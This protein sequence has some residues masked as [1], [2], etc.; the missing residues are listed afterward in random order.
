MFCVTDL[1]F[2]RLFGQSKMLVAAANPETLIS[3]GEYLGLVGFNP[4][5]NT[6]KHQLLLLLKK[7]P[8]TKQPR[9]SPSAAILYVSQWKLATLHEHLA[10][11]K[12]SAVIVC[13]RGW[14]KTEAAA[15]TISIWVEAVRYQPLVASGT[16]LW[17]GCLFVFYGD[18]IC[19]DLLSIPNLPPT[20][21]H[22]TI[23]VT[24]EV[25]NTSCWGSL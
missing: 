25:V 24:D 18:K 17:Q 19:F 16:I 11:N 12:P 8:S 10:G 9:H 6:I 1:K 5:P 14:E 15:E 4:S 21:S 22:L 13:C 7:H 2:G 23:S 3:T 20:S